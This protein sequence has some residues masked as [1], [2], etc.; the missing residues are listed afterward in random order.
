MSN[1]FVGN[2]Y[3]GKWDSIIETLLIQDGEVRDNNQTFYANVDG[4]FDEIIN[5]WKSAG[6]DK[7]DTVEWINFYPEK[8]FDS[9]VINE[10]E[11]FSGT[12][13]ARAWISRLRPGK[14]AP[15]HKDIDDQLEQYLAQGE[16]V[17]FSTFISQPYPGAVFIVDGQCFH[18]EDSGNTYE[19]TEYMDWHAG[20]NCGLHDQF[21]FHFLGVK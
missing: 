1:K 20:G 2:F 10:F 19:W 7:V 8:H 14:Y 12:K 13:C 11:K 3:K 18:C 16:L 9:L 21:M 5:L 17:R 6:Y 15:I 4:R